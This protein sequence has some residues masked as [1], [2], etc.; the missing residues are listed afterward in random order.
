MKILVIFLTV[1][2]TVECRLHDIYKDCGRIFKMMSII[3]LK[4]FHFSVFINK[5]SQTGSITNVSITDCDKPP[6][7]FVR[8]TYI[9][10]CYQ[11]G[12]FIYSKTI[13]FLGKNYTLALNFLSSIVLIIKNYFT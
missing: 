3:K 2:I 5:G 4:I 12:R 10:F 13:Y 11:I 1:F 8:G 9:Y 7:M 6:C